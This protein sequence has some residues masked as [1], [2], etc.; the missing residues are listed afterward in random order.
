LS[1]EA[2]EIVLRADISASED[3]E[4]VLK[5][6]R[7]VL[8]DCSYKVELSPQSLVLRSSDRGCLQKVHD[9]LRDRHVRDAARRQLLVNMEG[10][11]LRLLLNRQAAFVGVIASVSA[12]EES[13]L[14]PLV[15]ELQTD[16]PEEMLDWL[17]LYRSSEP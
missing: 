11:K 13:P 14:G 10:R 8:G 16:K 6:A 15:L 9:Q 3:P 1:G 17:T 5:A 12:A 7:N 4:R 2:V